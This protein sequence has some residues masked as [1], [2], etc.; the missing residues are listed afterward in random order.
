MRD[1]ETMSV[2]DPAAFA[3]ALAMERDGKEKVAFS[4]Y[5]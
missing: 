1:E 3:A 4:R 2:V 5:G